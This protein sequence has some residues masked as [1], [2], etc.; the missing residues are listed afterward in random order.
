ME[1][2][3]L[4]TIPSA[5]REDRIKACKAILKDLA[6][7][8]K[9]S[10]NRVDVKDERLLRL[11]FSGPDSEIFL[12]LLRKRWTIAIEDI[13]KLESGNI[14]RGFITGIRESHDSFKIDIG[15]LHPEGVFADYPIVAA[16]AQLADGKAVSLLD[17][18]DAY[19][20]Q[21]GI[22][23]EVR[24]VRV[25]RA[26]HSVTVWLS[27]SQVYRF[28]EWRHLP[29]QRVIV[30]GVL[31]SQLDLALQQK[32]ERDVARLESLSLL[33]HELTCKIGTEA[34]EVVQ[35]IRA[36]L[37]DAETF[38]FLPTQARSFYER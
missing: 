1:V 4:E 16:R 10:L 22:P 28:Q 26:E 31:R 15:I 35:R 6:S 23:V 20:L 9:I 25:D 3:V 33:V 24:I 11:L 13:S 18:A 38:I 17:I 21:P 8:L 36:R 37:P 7:G 14:L 27:D 30:K 2:L 5:R 34:I 12:E 32:V 19:S 29:F